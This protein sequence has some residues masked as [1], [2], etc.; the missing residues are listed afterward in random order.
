MNVSGYTTLNNTT[1]TSSLNV[2]G[3][4]ILNNITTINSSL[5]VSGT[6]ILNN[7]TT[8]ISSLFVSGLTVL[9][10]ALNVSGKQHLI[11]V[12]LI[13]CIIHL[14]HILLITVFHHTLH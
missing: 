12:V 14:E 10:S 4:T 2:S 13:F 7:A 3:L 6:T 1:C 11:I 9:N 8:N 5:Y